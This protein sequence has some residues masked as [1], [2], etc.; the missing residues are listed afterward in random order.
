MAI[1]ELTSSLGALLTLFAIQVIFY[2]ILIWCS[3]KIL[4][5]KGSISAIIAASAVA[6]LCGIIPIIGLILSLIVLILLINK[7]TKVGRL[8]S[9]LI[10]MMAWMLSVGITIGL[11]SLLDAMSVDI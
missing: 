2:T 1:F 6:A 4:R 9:L 10:V 3:M 11:F 8:N 5:K 7:F